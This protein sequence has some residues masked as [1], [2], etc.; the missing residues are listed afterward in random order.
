MASARPDRGADG[1]RVG[2]TAGAGWIPASARPCALFASASRR[3]RAWVDAA[4]ASPRRGGLGLRERAVFTRWRPR[5]RAARFPWPPPAPGADRASRLDS[6]SVRCSYAFA[7]RACVPGDCKPCSASSAQLGRPRLLDDDLLPGRPPR[8]RAGLLRLRVRRSI[9][10]GTRTASAGCPA[11]TRPCSP[12]RSA[13]ASV[14]SWS[15]CAWRSARRRQRRPACGL[16]QV[17]HVTDRVLDLLICSESTTRPSLL[18]STAEDCRTCAVS[19][20]RFGSLLDREAAHDGRR[21]PR[22]GCASCRPS[23][24]AGP[25]TGG[26]RLAIEARS[27]P[28]L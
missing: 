28:I 24:P 17:R 26:P 14:A 6:A 7:S 8:Q 13:S 10:P 9:W 16:A 12:M 5:R 11:T 25:E 2:Q 22:T 4:S 23:G 19:A 20:S 1:L 18:I 15:R 27:S 3:P 21:C